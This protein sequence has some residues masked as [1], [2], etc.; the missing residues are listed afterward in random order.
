MPMYEYHCSRCAKDFE[1]L[2]FGDERSVRCPACGSKKIRKLMS[3]CSHRSGGRSDYGESAGAG[4]GSS[5]C[6]GCSG[7]DCGSC[8]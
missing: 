1:E 7:G 6:S 3:R 2:V 4:S 5:G 8:H